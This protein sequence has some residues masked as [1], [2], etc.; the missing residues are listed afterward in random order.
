MKKKEKRGSEKSVVGRN[1]S[2][3]RRI[4]GRITKTTGESD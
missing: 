4:K 1:S 2:D 3:E